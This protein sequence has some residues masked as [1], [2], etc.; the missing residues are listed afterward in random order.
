[1]SEP[2]LV[3]DGDCGVCARLARL[4]AA[5]VRPR[6]E[7]FAVTAYQD[8]SLARLGLTAAQ[9]DQ[10]LQWV[11]ADGR[12]SSAQDAVAR[13]L[14][15][16]RVWLRPLGAVI[17]APGVNALAAVIYRWVAANRHRLPGGTPACSL[18]AAQRPS[19]A[20]P[21]RSLR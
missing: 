4:A 10:A 9:C 19:W 14:L 2:V 21:H 5:R 1:V 7:S 12:V 17:L 3:Y 15:S 11:A 8:I 13:V 20:P 6:P 18:P 16:G